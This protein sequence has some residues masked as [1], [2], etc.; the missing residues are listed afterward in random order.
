MFTFV[1]Y[2]NYSLIQWNSFHI[3]SS[4]LSL[5]VPLYV[6]FLKFSKFSTLDIFQW[7]FLSLLAIQKFNNSFLLFFKIW[8]KNCILDLGQQYVFLCVDKQNF[9]RTKIIRA[10]VHDVTARKSTG[11]HKDKF[12]FSAWKFPN[13]AQ[14][15]FEVVI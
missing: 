3:V 4:L 7:Y 12:K 1:Y 9:I 14:A 15:S 8:V 2:K 6:K 13:L 10:D 5:L 11:S